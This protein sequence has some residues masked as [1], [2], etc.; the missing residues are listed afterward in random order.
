MLIDKSSDQVR[1]RIFAAY[2]DSAP[3]R[4]KAV[5]F[6]WGLA[7]VIDQAG[8]VGPCQLENMG[9]AGS[10]VT[11]LKWKRAKFQIPGQ[12][13]RETLRWAC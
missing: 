9:S 11:I 12:G 10:A 4:P 1:L 2:A 6:P 5:G 7:I 3:G 8:Q 13:K